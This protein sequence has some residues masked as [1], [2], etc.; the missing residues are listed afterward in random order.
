MAL[1][2][3]YRGDVVLPVRSPHWQRDLPVLADG[4]AL[5]RPLR[6]DDA[7]SLVRH[8]SDAAVRRHIAPPPRTLHGFLRFIDWADAE[9]RKGVHIT[10]GVV[11][12]SGGPAVGIFQ[13]W[14][15]EPDFSTAEWGL[16]VG[17]EHW[18]TGLSE[19]AA[20]LL[21]QFAFGTI[22][23]KRLE[24]RSGVTNHRGNGLLRKL[25]ATVEGRLRQAFRQGDVVEDQ[26]LWSIL[27]SEWTEKFA[28]GKPIT[29]P[30]ESC[31]GCP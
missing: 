1:H 29:D 27:A 16:A 25:G 3:K 7:P 18:G 30:I 11:P 10:Y 5:L 14:R 19:A 12:P 23:V 17:A 9:R 4:V 8:L 2:E 31:H 6:D 26:Q 20:L 24:A 13:L 28:A 15:V 22:G 21:M